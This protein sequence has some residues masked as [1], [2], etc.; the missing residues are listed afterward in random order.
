MIDFLSLVFYNLGRREGKLNAQQWES[1]G[2]SQPEPRL[3]FRLGFVIGLV[4]GIVLGALF[5]YYFWEYW[6]FIW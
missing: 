1:Y 5:A 6:F 3:N 2:T 4:I